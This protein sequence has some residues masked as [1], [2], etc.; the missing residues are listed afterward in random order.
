MRKLVLGI[1][2]VLVVAGC[3]PKSR[4]D[5][6]AAEA[7]QLKKELGDES[8]KAAERQKQLEA[9]AATLGVSPE[10][11]AQ[12][13]S[14]LQKERQETQLQLQATSQQLESVA[15]EK[16][17]LEKKSGEYQQ[18]SKAMEK[19]IAAG[20]VQV[21]ELLGKM[22]IVLGD[23]ILFPS[24]SA[25]LSKK[26]MAALDQVASAFKDLKGKNILV[27][28]FT[29]DVP[30]SKKGPFEDNWDLS[31]ARAASVVRYLQSKGVDPSSLGAAG[32]SEYRPVASNKSEKGKAKN[33]RI[34]IA[35]TAKD[36]PTV[37]VAK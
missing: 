14:Q 15:K 29:D 20:Q 24:G 6:K 13:V 25:T 28:G 5:A 17:Q 7:E 23:E 4:Y 27:A 35:L 2:G 10:A 26:G 37:Q 32:Y 33:R 8:A 18:L 31:S 34:V 12:A 11:L 16:E 9:L 19:Q 1:I 36:M 21:S 30:V 3:I 22:T